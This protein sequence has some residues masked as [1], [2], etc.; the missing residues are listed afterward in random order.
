[1]NRKKIIIL[2]S[3]SRNWGGIDSYLLNLF[4]YYD[5]SKIDLTLVSL[6][7]WAVVREVEKHGGKIKVFSGKRFNP[8]T[9][10]KIAGYLRKEN[11]NLI[12]SGGLVANSYSRAVSLFSGVPHL[13]I[14]HSEFKYD[15][16]NPLI[17]FIYSLVLFISSWKTKRYI[18][19]S[20]YIKQNL[21]KS[22]INGKKIIVVYN[23]VDFKEITNK[24]N[25]DNK[26]I[27][28]SSVGRLHKVKGYENLIKAASLLKKD[29]W[30]IEIA[31]EG[32]EKNNLQVLI[33]S[34]NLKDKVKLLGH[35]EDI[36]KVYENTDIYIQPSLSEG[37]GL[38]VVEAMGFGL[39][40][41]VTPVGSLPEIV[42]DNETG[43]IAEGTDP[44][45][46]LG[47]M[48]KLIE[49]PVQVQKMGVLAAEDVRKRF[50]VKT[51]AEKTINVFLEASK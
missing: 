24:V 5:R 21:E 29:N 2:Y 50:D 34:L 37:F 7:N 28:I 49:N 44:D 26:K 19:V 46:L 39:P 32:Q 10:F 9:I 48:N 6:G 42:Q 45:S 35:V 16:P 27:I 25:E 31:G 15:Y 11:I 17:R 23:G 14:V 38:T 18:A 8:L 43:I 30:T 13:S 20:K 41:I 12:V 40:V 1:M 3:G 4:K 33:D 47:A 22:G 36:D 51:W